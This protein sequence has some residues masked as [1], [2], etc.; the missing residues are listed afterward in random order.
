MYEINYMYIIKLDPAYRLEASVEWEPTVN[1]KWQL[2]IA[3]GDT[4]DEAGM[5]CPTPSLWYCS[6][7]YNSPLDSCTDK[8]PFEWDA[9]H[10]LIFGGTAASTPRNCAETTSGIIQ[11]EGEVV[12]GIGTACANPKLTIRTIKK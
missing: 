12:L 2:N 3:E 7:F 5:K 4:P 1:P 10:Y 11:G 9:V 6:W 8:S